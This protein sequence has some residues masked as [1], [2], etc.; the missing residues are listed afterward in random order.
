MQGE[1]VYF[2]LCMKELKWND[3]DK[4]LEIFPVLY[5]VF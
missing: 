1:K 3:S 5:Q 2:L 4:L